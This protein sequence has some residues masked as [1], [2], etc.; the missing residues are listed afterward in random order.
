MPMAAI[1]APTAQQ[2][3]MNAKTR[4]QNRARGDSSAEIMAMPVPALQTYQISRQ[5]SPVFRPGGG[6]E[7]P[8]SPPGVGR[9]GAPGLNFP[10]PKR[11]LLS[12]EAISWAHEAGNPPLS[13]PR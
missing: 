3:I 10:A 13:L 4:R 11:F 12:W 9:A 8:L 6:V 7:K 2:S 5:F 1:T